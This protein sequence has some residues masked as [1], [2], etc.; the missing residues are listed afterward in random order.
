MDLKFYV[1]DVYGRPLF[2][3]ANEAA[4]VLTVILSKKKT[5]SEYEIKSLKKIK[6]MNI[7]FQNPLE[8]EFIDD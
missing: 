2:Y 5:L 6:G 1:K 4:T 7:E 3:P 8:K